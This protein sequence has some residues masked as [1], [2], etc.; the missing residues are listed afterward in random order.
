MVA[1]LENVKD[2]PAFNDDNL[3]LKDIIRDLGVGEIRTQTRQPARIKMN[4]KVLSSSYIIVEEE[5]T[6][7]DEDEQEKCKSV[8]EEDDTS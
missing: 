1:N 8:E 7:Y 4:E 2:E 3:I 6:Y 5:E